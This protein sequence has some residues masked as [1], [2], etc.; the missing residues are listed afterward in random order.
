ML[1]ITIIMFVS[2]LALSK[3]T[4]SDK[5]K[6]YCLFQTHNKLRINIFNDYAHILKKHPHWIIIVHFPTFLIKQFNRNLIYFNEKAQS[7]TAFYNE[8]FFL[9]YYYPLFFNG[10]CAPSFYKQSKKRDENFRLKL[11]WWN[12]NVKHFLLYFLL[13]PVSYGKED[14]K[15]D[16]YQKS[17]TF[18][19]H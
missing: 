13:R 2:R 9:V 19:I 17:I 10:N 16:I 7:S 8:V 12:R 6:Y 1:K 4:P 18:L 5:V 3:I 15:I 11:E 14:Y